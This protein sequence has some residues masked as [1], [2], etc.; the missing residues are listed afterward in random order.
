MDS[1]LRQRKQDWDDLQDVAEGVKMFED[2][3]A[4]F[5]LKNVGLSRDDKQQILLANQSTYNQEGIEKALSVSF[6]DVHERERREW[7]GGSR[8]G[9][10]KRSYAH[11]VGEDESQAYANLAE[12]D[13]VLDEYGEEAY[14][15]GGPES[16]VV[17]PGGG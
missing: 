2:L 13:E 6:F 7:S 10:G 16:G 11:L 3:L 14:D 9:S 8:K 12:G 15:D 4:Y 17:C 1:Y 5:T